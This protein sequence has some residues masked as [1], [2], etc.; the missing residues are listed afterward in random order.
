[1]TTMEQ[2]PPPLPEFSF[3][4]S[5]N[6]HNPIIKDL[7]ISPRA[8]PNPPCF[9]ELPLIT[10]LPYHLPNKCKINNKNLRSHP[11]ISSQFPRPKT[12]DYYSSSTLT[13]VSKDVTTKSWMNGLN[14][15][16]P[17]GSSRYLLSDSIL[18]DGFSGLN[19]V[20]PPNSSEPERLQIWIQYLLMMKTQFLFLPQ[21]L[22]K[23]HGTR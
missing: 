8:L 6:R 13:N 4:A 7:R 11:K 21:H 15:V 12:Y 5:I 19:P 16:T 14:L 2:L 10:P 22:H 1:M 23:S 3:E 20:S 17:H 18:F 9:F